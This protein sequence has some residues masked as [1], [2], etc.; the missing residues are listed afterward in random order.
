[1]Q[2]VIKYQG[3]ALPATGTPQVL[4]DSD[5][6]FPPGGSFHLL[7]QQW[8]QY[9]I[10]YTS[11]SGT[12]VATV[13]GQFA[14]DGFGAATPTWQTF[15]TGPAGSDAAGVRDEVYVGAYKDV[16]FLV[17]MTVNSTLTFSA[18]LA[19]NDQKASSTRDS[20]SAATGALV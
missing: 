6:A 9:R 2:T 18:N 12:G 15:Y 17:T 10:A 7:N 14:D 13:T 4:F 8:F 11:T 20:T 16:R 5:A 3:L 1:M 19:L